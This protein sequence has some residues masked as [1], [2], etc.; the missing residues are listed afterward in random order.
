MRSRKA[1]SSVIGGVLPQQGKVFRIDRQ[2]RRYRLV[3]DQAMLQGDALVEYDRLRY[4]LLPY[5]YS[6][7]WRV[8]HEGYTMMR[9]LPMD[10][11]AD[12]RYGESTGGD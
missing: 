9:A 3:L 5:L 11:G 4:R 12:P 10:F 1:A 2:I 7:A 6:V 8:T